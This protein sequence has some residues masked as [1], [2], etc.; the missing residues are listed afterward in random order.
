MLQACILTP[1]THTH[2]AKHIVRIRL[3]NEMQE[4]VLRELGKDLADEDDETPRDDEKPDEV[5]F[6]AVERALYRGGKEVAVTVLPLIFHDLAP[7]F[8]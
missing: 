1:P 3:S 6:E 8:K 7:S 4:K 2:T 5:S